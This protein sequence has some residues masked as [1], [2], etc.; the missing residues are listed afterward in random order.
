MTLLGNF[1][2]EFDNRDSMLAAITSDVG[3][4]VADDV[5]NY[6]PAGATVFHYAALSSGR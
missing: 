5:P 6:S 1:E 4:R 3:K 2:A